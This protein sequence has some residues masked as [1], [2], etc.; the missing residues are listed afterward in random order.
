MT[1][2]AGGDEVDGFCLTGSLL[3]WV[4]P[5]GLYL[6]VLLLPL[7]VVE[8][9]HEVQGLPVSCSVMIEQSCS[10][11]PNFLLTEL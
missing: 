7:L 11:F 2:F 6:S 4:L 3:F 5:P 9:E 10:A 1:L 8:T